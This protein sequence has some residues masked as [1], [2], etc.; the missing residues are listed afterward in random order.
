MAVKRPKLDD[1]DHP[2]SKLIPISTIIRDHQIDTADRL[3]S[4]LVSE[5]HRIS[6]VESS[7]KVLLP[8]L[9]WY[10]KVMP[11]DYCSSERDK[12][13]YVKSLLDRH[14]GLVVYFA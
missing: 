13:N 6:N 14:N 4:F 7:L 11:Y 3:K 10:H 8:K 2:C 5:Y 9:N 1:F 12:R